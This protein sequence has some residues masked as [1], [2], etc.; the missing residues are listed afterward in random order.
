MWLFTPAWKSK[1]DEKAI[2]AVERIADQETLALVARTALSDPVRATAVKKLE[3]LDV[4]ADI[5]SRVYSPALRSEAQKRMREILSGWRDESDLASVAKTHHNPEVCTIAASVIKS[6]NILHTLAISAD[7]PHAVRVDALNRLQDQA[8]L[9]DI[10][11]NNIDPDIRLAATKNLAD[12]KLR[13]SIYVDVIKGCDSH[14]SRRCIIENL[15]EYADQQALAEIAIHSPEISFWNGRETGETT[16]TAQDTRPSLKIVADLLTESQWLQYVA[17]HADNNEVRVAA[18]M[19][20]IAGITDQA[21]LVRIALQNQYWEVRYQA[22]VKLTDQKTLAAVAT[23]DRDRSV[24]QAAVERIT[25]QTVLAEIASTDQE[26]SVAD[27]A[28]KNLTEQSAILA[29]VRNAR[30]GISRA[31]LEKMTDETALGDIAKTGQWGSLR[32]DAIA[33]VTDPAVLTDIAEHDHDK[34][35]REAANRRLKAPEL[36]QAVQKMREKQ[37]IRDFQQDANAHC[38]SCQKKMSEADKEKP[39][40][41]NGELIAVCVDCQAL[42]RF[43]ESNGHIVLNENSR[44]DGRSR[45]LLCGATCWYDEDGGLE[46]TRFGLSPCN[47]G[48]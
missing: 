38:L 31:A 48:M 2:K 3:S 45:C 4:L 26:T 6:Q 10:A 47:P 42:Y 23:K 22:T 39:L 24:R 35:V 28:L 8:L 9:T 11:R 15:N 34:W 12:E 43:Y 14:I 27:A 37:L 40:I 46:G 36:R 41:H 32:N 17:Q 18:T 20:L 30:E 29:V 5:E 44:R 1:N 33:R 7:T 19:K 13:Q 16:S 25:D 21:Q